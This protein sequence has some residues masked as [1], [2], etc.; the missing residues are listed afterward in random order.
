MEH[1]L[2]TDKERFIKILNFTTTPGHT[3]I[4]PVHTFGGV[5]QATRKRPDSFHFVA[6]PYIQVPCGAYIL[7]PGGILYS[8]TLLRSCSTLQRGTDY[9]GEIDESRQLEGKDRRE[10]DKFV[11]EN[12]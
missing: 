1:L 9:Y 5:A 3:I 11:S 2:T 6:D 7:D 12:Q 4:Y 10:L 8:V